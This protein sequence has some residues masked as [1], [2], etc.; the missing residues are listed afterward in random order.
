MVCAIL[1][2]SILF[3]IR[4]ITRVNEYDYF[5]FKEIILRVG[6]DSKKSYS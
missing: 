3:T 2:K 6:K 4:G 1:A 5:V